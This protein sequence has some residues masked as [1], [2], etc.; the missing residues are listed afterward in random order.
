VSRSG[1]AL[2]TTK[3]A[4]LSEALAEDVEVVGVDEV[5]MFSLDDVEVVGELLSRGSRVVAAG[6]DLDH[7]G[8]LF[9]PVKALLELGPASV[10]YRRSVCDRCR[11]FAATHTQVLRTGYPFTEPLGRSQAL[12]DDGTFTYEARCRGCF[13]AEPALIDSPE[14][15][16][17]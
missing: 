12:P 7:R 13:V 8:E 9:A 1:G 5:H 15:R 3:V 17:S 14:R 10:T 4:D 2:I 16:A 6:L 11:S